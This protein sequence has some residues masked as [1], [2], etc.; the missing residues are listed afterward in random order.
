[1]DIVENSTPL[2]THHAKADQDHHH[3]YASDQDFDSTNTYIQ[4]GQDE[5]DTVALRF[6]PKDPNDL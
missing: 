4:V 3:G 5:L 1:M 2:N 6:V